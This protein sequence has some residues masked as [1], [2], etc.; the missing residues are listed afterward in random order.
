MESDPKIFDRLLRL[1][2][3]FGW[4]TGLAKLEAEIRAAENPDLRALLQQLSGWVAAERGDH[5]EALRQLRLTEQ[6]PVLAGWALYGQA[7]VEL[8]RKRFALV[9]PLLDRATRA[10]DPNDTMLLAR[11]ALFRGLAHFHEGQTD[12]VLPLLHEALEKAGQASFA[13]GRVLDAMGQVYATRDNFHAAREFY[14]QSLRLKEEFQDEAGLALG[15]GQLGRLFLDWG[16]L[17]QAQEHFEKD[18]A[19]ARRIG[20][21]RGEAQ[22]YNHLGQVA[23]ARADWSAAAAWL[24]EAVRRSQQ[25]RHD[26]MEGYARKDR[27]LAHL[28]AGEVAAAEAEARRAEELFRQADF[29]E[30]LAHVSGVLGAVR[31]AQKQY[32]EAERSLR[33]ALG[34]FEAQ[35]ERAEAARTQLEVART[36]RERGSPRP[37][38]V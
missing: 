14:E 32:Q 15:H 22:V 1:L 13:T 3:Q 29:M 30:G 27:A 8:R 11:I 36:Q 5:E 26:Y 37:L 23:L 31:R 16:Y 7:F 9:H 4:E 18:L 24:D 20:D 6:V 17:D 33:S 19:I 10:A 21:G 12:L 2:R 25:G 34:Y 38:V 28:G 35:G